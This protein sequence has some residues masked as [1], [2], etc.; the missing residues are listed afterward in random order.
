MV[1]PV[2]DL[3]AVLEERRSK[4]SY[5]LNKPPISPPTI[6]TMPLRR[7][8]VGFKNATEPQTKQIGATAVPTKQELLKEMLRRELVRRGTLPESGGG[9]AGARQRATASPEEIRGRVRAFTGAAIE[10][11]PVVG[12][13]L[14]KGADYVSSL[15]SGTS[16]ERVAQETT[17]AQAEH[18]GFSTAGAGVG[19]VAPLAGLGATGLGARALGITGPSVGGRI[20]AATTSGGSISAGDTAARGGSGKDIAVSAATGAAVSPIAMGLGQLAGKA[21]GAVSKA[22]K[23]QVLMTEAQ[24][25]LSALKARGLQFTPTAWGHVVNDIRHTA[26][27]QGKTLPKAMN[28]AY[29]MRLS[30]GGSP[31]LEE[32]DNFRQVLE[33]M[34]TGTN[35]NMVE[36]AIEKVDSFLSNVS[37]TQVARQRG[38]GGKFVKGSG[39]NVQDA[40]ELRAVRAELIQAEKG[41]IIE[42]MFHNAMREAKGR[43]KD[44]EAALRNEFTNLSKSAR[45]KKFSPVEQAAIDKVV[46][47]GPVTNAL[48]KIGSYNRS[49][50][51]SAMGMG[52]GGSIGGAVGF[53]AGGGLPGAFVGAAGGASAVGLTAAGARRAALA[54]TGRSAEAAREQML[55]GG[56]ID[57]LAYPQRTFGQALGLGTELERRRD[58]Y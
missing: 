21:V 52:A 40:R 41:E 35:S 49:M 56:P 16:P 30:R 18:P 55:L 8:D 15:K 11:V 24:A 7:G 14:K 31:T 39:G 4:F 20:A 51:S 33:E 50:L 57:Q 46:A 27:Q 37:P 17:A 32:V 13:S 34:R 36:M 48:R 23:S 26:A 38:P 54:R 19:T 42:G 12:P 10:A 3:A 53:A 47:G 22:P 44:M 29:L 43:N 5:R 9:P 25:R 58:G 1:I 2:P 6:K 45:M 28:S